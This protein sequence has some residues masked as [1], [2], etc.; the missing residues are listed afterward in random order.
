MRELVDHVRRYLDDPGLDREARR[1]A[2]K[3]ECGPLDGHSGRRV[4]LALLSLAGARPAVDHRTVAADSEAADRQP[5][6]GA[7]P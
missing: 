2:A 3:R 1:R 6:T 5:A 4:G 7:L